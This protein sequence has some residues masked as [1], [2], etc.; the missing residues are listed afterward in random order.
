MAGSGA[1]AGYL[2]E[3]AQAPPIHPAPQQPPRNYQK[4]PC[5]RA[6]PTL[7]PPNAA[8]LLPMS[9]ARAMATIGVEPPAFLSQSPLKSIAVIL[10]ASTSPQRGQLSP[11]FQDTA[12]LELGVGHSGSGIRITPC[13]SCTA[14]WFRQCAQ[15]RC[16]RGRNADMLIRR[17]SRRQAIPGSPCGHEAN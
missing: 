5:L 6:L 16:T 13:T 7:G 9:S 14:F 2:E 12:F 15:E 10:A 8:P 3:A 11:H 17:P 4:S 1:S